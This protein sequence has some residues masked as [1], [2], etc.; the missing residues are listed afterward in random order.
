MRNNCDLLID[1][2]NGQLTKEEEE[3]F[4]QHL[5][6]CSDCKEELAELREMTEDLPFASEPVEPTEGMK[7]RVLS[8]VFGEENTED[9]LQESSS[10]THSAAPS[11]RKEESEN[12]LA[13]RYTRKQPRGIKPWMVTT[14]AAALM[15]SLIGN[16][17]AFLQEPETTKPD[18]EEESIDQVVR[19]V[20][21][22]GKTSGKATASIIKQNENQ[23]LS[24]DAQNLQQLEGEEVY[25]VWLLEGETPYRAGSFVANQNGEGAVSFSMDQLPNDKTWDMIA[26]SKEPDAT[27]KKPRGNIVLSTKF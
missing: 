10:T 15:L 24:V 20:T 13:S 25:Q 4:E 9:E 14:L 5:E 6:T 26:I 2:F 12:E 18:P 19:R 7:N 17:Y 23:I 27:S 16:M 8:G 3:A 11:Y 21:L 22:Q 1:Y